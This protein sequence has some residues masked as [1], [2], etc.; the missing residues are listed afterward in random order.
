MRVFLYRML[1][2]A[3]QFVSVRCV[4]VLVVYFQRVVVVVGDDDDDDGGG[5]ADNKHS[6]TCT[7][8]ASDQRC[9]QLGQVYTSWWFCGCACVCA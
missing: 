7:R 8:T 4:R 1:L 2:L 9:Q 3:T 6:L 5:V